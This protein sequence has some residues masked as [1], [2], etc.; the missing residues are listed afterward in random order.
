MTPIFY[1]LNQ[2]INL[3]T[4]ELVLPTVNSNR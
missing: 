3:Y 4:K 1:V 2:I